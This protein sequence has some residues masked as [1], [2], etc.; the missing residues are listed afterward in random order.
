MGLGLRL[1]R[2]AGLRRGCRRR[3]HAIEFGELAGDAGHLTGEGVEF[4]GKPTDD[5]AVRFGHAGNPA[6]RTIQT[7]E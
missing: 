6:G 1:R 5:S 4:F 2:R 7:D 3:D